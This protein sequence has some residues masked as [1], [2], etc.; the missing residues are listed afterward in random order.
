MEN[1]SFNIKENSMIYK[2]RKRFMIMKKVCN[3]TRIK[4]K[5]IFKQLK[6]FCQRIGMY[7]DDIRSNKSISQNIGINNIEITSCIIK[8]MI[9]DQAIQL[10]VNK[11]GA[12][13]ILSFSTY[14]KI[15][16]TIILQSSR[17][18]LHAVTG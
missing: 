3:V 13:N 14:E 7:K 6:E 16:T 4:D 9:N 12:V 18:V 11:G 15:K 17:T 1:K 2:V 8:G 10:E 5:L